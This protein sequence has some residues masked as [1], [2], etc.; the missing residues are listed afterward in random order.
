MVDRT[1]YRQLVGRF[2]YLTHS[3]P[4]LY[5]VVGIVY[6]FMQEPHELHWKATK[7]I[8][9]YA[10]VTCCGGKSPYGLANRVILCMQI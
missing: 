5:Y 3:R 6:R 4:D 10:H 2:L 1:L 8:L 9:Q 7:C